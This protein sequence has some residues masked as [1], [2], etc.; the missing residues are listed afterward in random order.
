MLNENKSKR[1][2][3]INNALN[4]IGL[5]SQ[6]NNEKQ[7]NLENRSSSSIPPTIERKIKEM[8]RESSVKDINNNNTSFKKPL[9]LE[10]NVNSNSIQRINNLKPTINN[11]IVE[12]ESE[13]SNI[14]FQKD[15]QEKKKRF[16]NLQVKLTNIMK[17]EVKNKTGKIYK[18]AEILSKNLNKL[19]ETLNNKYTILSKYKEKLTLVLEKEKK[20]TDFLRNMLSNLKLISKKVQAKLNDNQSKLSE[21]CVNYIKELEN[22]MNDIKE[23]YKLNSD[24]Y[25]EIKENLNHDN[26]IIK[27]KMDDIQNLKESSINSILSL[28]YNLYSKVQEEVSNIAEEREKLENKFSENFINIVNV[29][30]IEFDE[31]I[32]QREYFEQ[33]FLKLLKETEE[34]M[35]LFNN[36][37]KFNI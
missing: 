23:K 9:L 35:N 17:D 27:D 7:F 4:R 32:N 36:S 22:K 6:T 16:E 26:Q 1:K 29:S 14:R 15:I 20:K 28:T 37:S 5:E 10:N 18:K 8:I 19:N 24:F 11:V 13:E 25:I 31:E 30:N 3:D 12:K 2:F 21:K 34:N 33:S